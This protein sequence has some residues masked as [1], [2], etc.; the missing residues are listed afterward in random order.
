M[1]KVLFAFGFLA[2]T[3]FAANAQTTE[4][5]GVGSSQQN[6]ESTQATA[7]ES[8]EYT[9]KEAI[10]QDELP[11]PVK[12]Q[13]QGSDYSGW[14]VSEV[15]RKEKDGQTFYAVKMKNAGE[16]KMVKF[17]AQGTKIKEKDEDE[18]KKH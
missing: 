13:I 4:D 2:A 7:D 5:Q 8:Q 11:T 1:K 15:Y 10:S 3:T 6:T 14:T 12:E 18:M 16:E 9:D 17:D